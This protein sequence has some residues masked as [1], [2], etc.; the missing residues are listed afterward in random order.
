[1][2]PSL[3]PDTQLASW[4]LRA[5]AL[6]I[7]WLVGGV[8][9][10]ILYAVALAMLTTANTLAAGLIVLLAMYLLAPILGFAFLAWQLCRAGDRNGQTIGKRAVGIRIV[11]ADGQPVN[12]VT[13]LLRHVVIGVLYLVTIGVGLV[14]DFLWPLW[15]VHRQA[16]HDKLAGTY[17]VL[18]PRG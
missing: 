15:D 2:P 6:L 12:F 10:A 17:V 1:M 8:A 9:G 11:R 16:L 13:V 4:A 3:P 5:G 18:S 14:A 7:D